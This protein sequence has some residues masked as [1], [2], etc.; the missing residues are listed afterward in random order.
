[1][2]KQNRLY[3]NAYCED[4]MT[5]LLIT[6]RETSCVTPQEGYKQIIQDT[7][8]E[9]QGTSQDL[10]ASQPSD[11][12]PSNQEMITDQP[13]QADLQEEFDSMGLLTQYLGP[14][15]SS[16][17]RR[18]RTDPESVVEKQKRTSKRNTWN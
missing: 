16:N 6:N 10:I 17:R 8:E 14:S 13:D 4:E 18:R 1:M 5:S 7:Q 9:Y 2:N 12:L 3:K 15:G 11:D